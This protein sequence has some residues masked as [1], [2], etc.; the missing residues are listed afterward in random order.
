MGVA[1]QRGQTSP[2]GHK[3]LQLESKD[4]EVPAAQ[5]AARRGPLGGK[6]E[7][8]SCKRAGMVRK[9]KSSQWTYAEMRS[10]KRARVGS[11]RTLHAMGMG[12]NFTPRA[13]GPTQGA[14]Q[15]CDTRTVRA[16]LRLMDGTWI[17]RGKMEERRP[18]TGY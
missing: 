5:R 10:E 2:L 16:S 18:R 15:W 3:S 1:L 13:R 8:F 7:A 9:Q 6:G 14:K 4:K 12:A 11:C 17:V